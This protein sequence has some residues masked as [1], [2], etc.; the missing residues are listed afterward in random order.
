V[1]QSLGI[2]CIRYALD[3]HICQLQDAI[4]ASDNWI[5]SDAVANLSWNGHEGTRVFDGMCTPYC[6]PLITFERAERAGEGMG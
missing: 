4:S 5:I 2:L 1:N 3:C 6:Y